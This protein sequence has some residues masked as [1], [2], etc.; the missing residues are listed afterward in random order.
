V[1]FITFVFL[2]IGIVDIF[3][4]GL[5]VFL[6][7]VAVLLLGWVGLIIGGVIFILVSSSLITLEGDILEVVESSKEV[8][9]SDL[10]DNLGYKKES[11]EDCSYIT[12]KS[13]EMVIK[14]SEDKKIYFKGENLSLDTRIYF[15]EKKG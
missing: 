5:I 6:L 10:L 8:S 3:L 9:M 12:C 7:L 4:I 1:D 13:Y 15:P 11:Y 14:L 2:G